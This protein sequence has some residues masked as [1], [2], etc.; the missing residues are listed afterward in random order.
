MIRQEGLKVKCSYLTLEVGWFMNERH[1]MNFKEMTM[2]TKN[3]LLALLLPLFLFC[4]TPLLATQ[5]DYYSPMNEQEQADIRYIITTLSEKS[6]PGLLVAKGSLESAGQRV[7]NVHPLRFLCFIFS[8]TDLRVAVYNVS[9][10]SFVWKQFMDGMGESLDKEV[11]RNNLN[12]E[13]LNDFLLT[14]DVE[15]APVKPH[16][17]KQ[18]WSKFVKAVIDQTLINSGAIS[19]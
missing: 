1:F 9:Q 10:R 4:V 18:K 5:R 19:Y 13:H 12:N 17:D 11:V 15:A 14:I 6:Y 16:F 8:E 7:E 2:H 3:R